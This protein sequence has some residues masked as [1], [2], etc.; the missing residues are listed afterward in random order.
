MRYVF[1]GTVEVA[2]DKDLVTEADAN[3]ECTNTKAGVIEAMLTLR[4]RG[5]EGRMEINES[6]VW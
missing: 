4:A 5:G 1:N 2:I 6:Y 3:T